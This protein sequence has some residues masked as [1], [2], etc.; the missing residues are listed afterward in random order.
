M[1]SSTRK[2]QR[3]DSA[4][5]ASWE[6]GWAQIANERL[7][8]SARG[9]SSPWLAIKQAAYEIP[10]GANERGGLMGGWGQSDQTDARRA[11]FDEAMKAADQQAQARAAVQAAIDRGGESPEA[12]SR[13]KAF[14][15]APPKL[16]SVWLNM[17]PQF[18]E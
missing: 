8:N 14:L 15:A 16:P 17:Y 10:L 2:Q 5:A 12:L 6:R 1:S 18:Q 7:K 4:D 3:Q 11:A 13:G 9:E